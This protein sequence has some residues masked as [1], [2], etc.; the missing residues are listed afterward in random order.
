M[1]E[2]DLTA[3]VDIV[4]HT[5]MLNPLRYGSETRHLA[6]R[7]STT[8]TSSR[9]SSWPRPVLPH[10]SSMNQSLHPTGDPPSSLENGAPCS[11]LL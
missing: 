4:W 10:T 7:S 3:V 11:G 1:E 6:S 8:R 2:L 5:H 9:Q